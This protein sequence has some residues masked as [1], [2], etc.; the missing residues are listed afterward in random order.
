MLLFVF[1][2]HL[3]LLLFRAPAAR[4]QSILVVAVG[5]SNPPP[6]TPA[7]EREA[8]LPPVRIV[9]ELE[10]RIRQKRHVGFPLDPTSAGVV[11]VLATRNRE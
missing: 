1:D 7:F 4:R 11:L 8:L 5:C 9:N 2:C 6:P 3:F 10:W